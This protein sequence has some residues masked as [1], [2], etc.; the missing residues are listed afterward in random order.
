M[1]IRQYP[2][3]EK[4]RSFGTASE[5]LHAPERWPVSR[6]G[7]SGIHPL[8]PLGVPPVN[9]GKGG[10]KRQWGRFDAGALQRGDHGQCLRRSGAINGDGSFYHSSDVN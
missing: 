5:T 7:R 10:I 1:R 2:A 4:V 9:D 8:E 3:F 6:S